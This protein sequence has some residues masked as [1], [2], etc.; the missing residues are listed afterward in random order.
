[1]N[2][3]RKI[4]SSP[5]YQWVAT[6]GRLLLLYLPITWMKLST[7]GYLFAFIYLTACYIS[8]AGLFDKDKEEE[9]KN[10]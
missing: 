9:G 6:T 3:F 7:W 10:T 1:M 5:I 8:V 4:N 2:I